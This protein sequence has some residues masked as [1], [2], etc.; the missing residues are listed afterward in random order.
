LIFK[1]GSAELTS[2]H[3]GDW[4]GL[5]FAYAV[6]TEIFKEKYKA[7]INGRPQG[8]GA[9]RAFAPLES[10]TNNQNFLKN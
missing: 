3:R 8:G 6:I 5:N 7:A 1:F 2:V 9:K 4:T 10:K